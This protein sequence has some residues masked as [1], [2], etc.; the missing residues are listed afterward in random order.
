MLAAEKAC[1]CHTKPAL[2]ALQ[3]TIELLRKAMIK[4]SANNFPVST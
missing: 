2:E 3:V 1:K 4:S